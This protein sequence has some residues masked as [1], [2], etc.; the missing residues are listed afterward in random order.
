M[1]KGKVL[2]LKKR[3]P[4]CDGVLHRMSGKWWCLLCQKFVK[5]RS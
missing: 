3:C 4:K 5:P 1:N 2:P